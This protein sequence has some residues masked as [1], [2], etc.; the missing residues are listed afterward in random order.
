MGRAGMPDDVASAVIFLASD[1]ASFITGRDL[2]IDGGMIAGRRYSDSEAGR[3]AMKSA[4]AP[5]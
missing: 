1:E 2:V 4:L 5:E 3:R